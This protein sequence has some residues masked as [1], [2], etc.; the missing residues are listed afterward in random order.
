MCLMMWD[1]YMAAGTGFAFNFA[2]LGMVALNDG[3]R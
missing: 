1:V 3:G 2:G